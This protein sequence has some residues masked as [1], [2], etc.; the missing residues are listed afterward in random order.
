MCKLKKSLY[1]LNQSLKAWFKRFTKTILTN[2]YS[3]CQAHHTLFVKSNQEGM[4]A[5]FIEY[6]HDIILTENYSTELKTI[7][8]ILASEFEIK[9]LGSLRY[10]MGMKVAR[11]KKSIVISQRKY[12]ID[13]LKERSMLG[14]KP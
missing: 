5:I 13:L 8:E 14:C 9:D 6:V 10:F 2:D 11:Y 7:K 1:G 3:Q 12:V 4:I